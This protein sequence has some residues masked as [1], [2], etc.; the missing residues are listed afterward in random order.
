MRFTYN[1]PDYAR[2]I[3]DAVNV[4]DVIKRYHKLGHSKGRT[5]CPIHNG[6]HDN[7]SYN[8]TMWHCFKCGEGGDAITFVEKL[9]GLDFMG[10]VRRIADDFNICLDI[11]SSQE[12]IRK[13]ALAKLARETAKVSEDRRKQYE[14]YAASRLC[15]YYRWLNSLPSRN[16]TINEQMSR[17]DSMI[18]RSTSGGLH[19]DYD[20]DAMIKSMGLTVLSSLGYND[21]EIKLMEESK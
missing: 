21:T 7:L 3:K 12:D 16:K 20:I 4:E 17:T 15:E 2:I 19:I 10:A 9:F 14:T 8:K 6:T 13:S 5:S 18:D 11:K 1:K